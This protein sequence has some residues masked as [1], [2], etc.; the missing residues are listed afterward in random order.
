MSTPASNHDVVQPTHPHA[1]TGQHIYPFKSLKPPIFTTTLHEFL[2]TADLCRFKE[3]EKKGHVE[4]EF[5]YGRYGNP[6]VR[7]CEQRLAQ[8]DRGQDA[9]F[10][11]SGMNAITTTLAALL[12]GHK[13]AH[14]IFGSEGYRRTRQFVADYL[15]HIDIT[16]LEMADFAQIEQHLKPTTKIVF[17]ELPTN[18]YLKVVDVEKLAKKLPPDVI[19]VV[20]HTFAT[21][22]NH[23]PLEWGAHLVVPS[24]T[25][26]IAGHN[27]A[28]GGAVIGRADLCE[29]V[30]Q[31][32]GIFGGMP[33]AHSA[34]ATLNGLD[35]LELKMERQNATGLAVAQLLE[36]SPKIDRVW[37]PGLKSHPDYET[38][39]KLFSGHGGVVSFEVKGG[40]NDA[41]L[42]V[43]RFLHHCGGFAHI[44]PSFGGSET[45]I[46]QPSLISFYELTTAQR[47]A[48]G[49]KDNLIRLSVGVA[50]TD[51][52]LVSIQSALDDLYRGYPGPEK[53]I[54]HIDW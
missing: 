10:F 32:R 5:E 21:P 3:L 35:D 27:D 46:E 43:D 38:A 8:L 49:I 12:K 33:T 42:F 41:S 36:S 19:L 7:T 52:V 16:T 25:K 9:V 22:I 28:L 1:P 48:V 18:P 2:D 50:R 14:I 20:D 45:L 40:L 31:A 15:P 24:T 53:E 6:T 34:Y 26:Y 11:P 47:L 39:K 44:G 23:R 4:G 17:F 51:V 37:Y 30:R 13:D 29:K 54:G